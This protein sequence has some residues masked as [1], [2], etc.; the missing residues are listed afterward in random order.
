M[1]RKKQKRKE[2]RGKSEREGACTLGLDLGSSFGLFSTGRKSASLG[3]IT[4]FG[5]FFLGFN[6]F[7]FLFLFFLGLSQ[8][9]K[10]KGKG[11]ERKMK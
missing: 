5:T 2:E 6:Y 3:R 1:D 9:E 10:E 11:K 8:R 7:L 4:G